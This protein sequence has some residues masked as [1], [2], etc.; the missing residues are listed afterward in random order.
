MG[1]GHSGAI[2]P[3][4]FN[5]DRFILA[6]TDYFTKWAEADSFKEIKATTVVKFVKTHVL[7][8][9]GTPRRIIS[10]NGAAFK[11]AKIHA[12]ADKFKIDWRYSSIYNPRAN[13]LAEAFNK[14][15][16]N[17]VKKTVN[18]AHRNWNEKVQE[19]LWAYRITFRTPTQATP[20]SLVFGT[21]AILPLEIEIPSLRTALHYRMTKEEQNKLRLEE[22]DTLD[23]KRLVAQQN[24]EAYQARMARAY[25]KMARIRQ[26]TQGELVLVLR[27]PIIGRHIGPKF[28][29]NWEGPYVIEKVFDGGAYQ[30][31]NQDGERVMP[32]I[33][34]RYLKKYYP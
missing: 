16:I 26:F 12:L 25:D 23:E 5:G 29:S 3:P 22:L 21:E 6:F 28:Q 14:T 17:I 31:V 18:D 20:Y 33:N 9:F 32:P 8:R 7:Y 24:L 30:L 34:G 10:D 15:L 19:A 11:N 13:G 1:S 27:R 2:D 4:A